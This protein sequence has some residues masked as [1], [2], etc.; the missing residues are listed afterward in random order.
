MEEN[1]KLKIAYFKEFKKALEEMSKETPKDMDLALKHKTKALIATTECNFLFSEVMFISKFLKDTIEIQDE[2]IIKFNSENL[3]KYYTT[4]LFVEK[5]ELKER[6]KGF[7]DS[8]AKE[9]YE[10]NQL[11]EILEKM[12]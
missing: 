10:N 8:K 11:T 1:L 12:S 3:P 2:D 6:V 9:I 5:G 4:N 7:V